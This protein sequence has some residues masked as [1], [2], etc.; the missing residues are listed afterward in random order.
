MSFATRDAATSLPDCAVPYMVPH[1]S[2]E[3]LELLRRAQASPG[4][5][6]FRALMRLAECYGF[7]MRRQRGSH[8]IFDHPTY[9]RLMVLQ[10]VRGHAKP[11]QVRQLLRALQEL[12]V[13]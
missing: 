13:E 4:S 8:V 3:C 7:E 10:D 5:L 1:R 11:Y 2:Q 12:G 6:R 9:E